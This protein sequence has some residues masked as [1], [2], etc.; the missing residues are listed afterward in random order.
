VWTKSGLYAPEKGSVS[1]W[2]FTIARNLRIDRL[3]REHAVPV[4]ELGDHDETSD[5]PGSDEILNRA[6]E[7]R[8]VSRALTKIP[9]EQREVLIL[10]YVEDVP[11]SEIAKRLDLPL[12]TVKS[13]MRLAYRRLRQS[14]ETLT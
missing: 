13:R 1:T 3:R 2:V 9:S 14:L 12:G 6:E 11:Q 5:E 8:L 7:D 4:S 10:S